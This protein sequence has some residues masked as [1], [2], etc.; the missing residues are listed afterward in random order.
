VQP[1]PNPSAPPDVTALLVLSRRQRS[2]FAA[3]VAAT[4][5]WLLACLRGSPRTRSLF[6][7]DH[8]WEDVLQETYLK[9][10]RNLARFDPDRG[11]GRGW[12]WQIAR[13]CAIDRYR[14]R[15]RRFTLSL[16]A[17]GPDARTLD[18]PS[19]GPG[20]EEVLA[21]KELAECVRRAVAAASHTV[22]QIWERRPTR[23]YQEIADELGL[24]RASV[25]ALFHRWKQRLEA[26]LARQG[27]TR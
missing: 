25:I 18:V 2:A 20:P 7:S 12:L 10:W 13:S 23:T 4:E 19:P 24:T 26:G 14:R 15:R 5:A 1:R 9:A 3:V 6:R 8:D 17:V 21:E 22:R 27:Y 11:T 16:S